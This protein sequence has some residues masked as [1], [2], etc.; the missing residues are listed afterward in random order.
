MDHAPRFGR[1]NRGLDMTEHEQKYHDMCRKYGVKWNDDSPRFVNETKES[2]AQK[3]KED[4]HLNNVPLALW[5]NLAR[6]FTMYGG[7]G[8]SLSEAVC[9][10]KHAALEL[11]DAVE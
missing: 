4:K 6:S 10:Q 5:D 1:Y 11:I 3:Y 2:L 7:R 9:V 8:L